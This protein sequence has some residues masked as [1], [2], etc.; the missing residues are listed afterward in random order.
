MYLIALALVGIL[1]AVV[2]L[3]IFNFRFLLY[4]VIPSLN[5]INSAKHTSLDGV[6]LFISDL[7]LRADRQ[8]HYRDAIRQLLQERQAS[9][10]IV[11][12][13]LFDSPEDGRQIIGNN[14]GSPIAEILGVRD[15]PIKTFF[16][17]GSPG[18]DFRSKQRRALNLNP[19]VQLGRCAYL[20]FKQMTVI[21]YHGHDLSWKG[22]I[23]H[24]WDRFISPL[25]IE[26]AW[27]KLAGVPESDW[28]IFGHTHL[29]GID[30]E[31]RIANCGGWQTIPLLVRPAC[32]GVLLS[33]QK[34]SL[35]V[36]NFAR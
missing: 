19:L 9:N 15:M 31:H 18:H 34:A 16:I 8:F 27:K 10:L 28:V 3:M 7:H 30:R 1:I 24:A 32:T 4:P 21:A 17:E 2:L 22:M 29:P 6:S 35:E 26:R 36:V 14:T 23:G 33:P 12:G 25:S 5:P 20:D 11:V 13:D